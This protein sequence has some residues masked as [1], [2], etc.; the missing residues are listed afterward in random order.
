MR[1]AKV[2]VRTMGGTGASSWFSGYETR[3]T[4]EGQGE[5]GKDS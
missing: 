5:K 2:P 3:S 1:A 4:W